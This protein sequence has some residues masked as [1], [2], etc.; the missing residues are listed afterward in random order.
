M[1]LYLKDPKNSIPNLLCT[2]NSYNKWAGYKINLEKSLPF[3]YTKNE[4][5]EK[6]YMETILFTVASKKNQIPRSNLNKGYE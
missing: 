2:I 6:D 4:Q 3:L 5:A 1:F